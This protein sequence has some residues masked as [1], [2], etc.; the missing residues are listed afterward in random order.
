MKKSTKNRII[1]GTAIIL[2]LLVV[3]GFSSCSCNRESYDDAVR[4]GQEKLKNGQYEEAAYHLKR[5]AKLSPDNYV[6]LINLGM[7]YYNANNYS[8]AANA[9]EKAILINPTEEALE[10]LGTTRLKQNRYEDANAA[11]TKAL[12]EY[13]RK[14]NLIA[15]IAACQYRM[16]NP[17]HAFDYLKEA[18]SDNPLNPVALYNMAVLKK[19]SN[20]IVEAANYFILFFDVV[21]ENLYKVQLANA[22]KH[23]AEVCAKYPAANKEEA[24]VI[25]NNAVNY[26]KQNK[27][28]ES[29]IESLKA[30]KIDPTETQYIA[31]LIGI[32]KKVGREE[33]VQR[34]TSR[35]KNGFPESDYAKKLK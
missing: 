30:T 2:L 18:L 1:L 9:F 27:L 17:K 21:D 35:I 23:F 16:G 25:Y 13:G 4:F 6:I 31:L 20:E 12:T 15:G 29:F 34:L 8:S 28:K 33:N 19:E 26:Y 32:S 14:P 11:Y 22:Q 7:A 24:R 10:A 3:L 5:A